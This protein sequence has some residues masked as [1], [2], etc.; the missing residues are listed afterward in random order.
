MSTF[1]KPISN[2]VGLRT[3][4]RHVRVLCVQLSDNPVTSV[5]VYGVL[6]SITKDLHPNTTAR[7]ATLDVRSVP[8]YSDVLDIY[9]ALRRQRRDFVL[10]HAGVL[11]AKPST[12]VDEKL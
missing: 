3:L 8:I 12:V 11:R 10:L 6:A 4:L 1:T 5:G 7:L 2:A 9:D